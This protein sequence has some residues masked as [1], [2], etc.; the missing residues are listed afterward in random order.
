[1]NS[2]GMTFHQLRQSLSGPATSVP[3]RERDTIQRVI[4]IYDL[5]ENRLRPYRIVGSLWHELMNLDKEEDGKEDDGFSMPS[6]I[7]P[8]S[9]TVP[10][11]LSQNHIK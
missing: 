1:M 3:T 2:E 7:K 11:Q 4:H 5:F 8:A 6:K 10:A 9:T